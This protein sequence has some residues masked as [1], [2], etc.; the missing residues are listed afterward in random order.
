MAPVT[1]QQKERFLD[2]CRKGVDRI[3][4]ARAVGEQ[5]STF[6]ILSLDDAEFRNEMK[7]ALHECWRLRRVEHDAQM[8]KEIRNEFLELIREGK[9]PKEAAQAVG[10]FYWQFARLCNVA[11][12]AYNPDF[13]RAY[14]EALAEGH[15]AFLDRIRHLQITAA[16]N[17]EYRAIR[18]LVIMH[19]PEGEKL[20]SKKVEVR[21]GDLDA[22]KA[23]A[24]A[25]DRSKVTDAEMELM[26]SILE[27]AT[28]GEEEPTKLELVS[29]DGK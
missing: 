10:G 14:R 7:A 8:T 9:H 20:S 11:N 23:A 27:K 21:D 1:E 6:Q 24:L 18:D 16:E 3:E 28:R 26:I 22:L 25:L 29:G 4:A 2:L 19:L 17:G 13:A 12:R 15:P 5:A